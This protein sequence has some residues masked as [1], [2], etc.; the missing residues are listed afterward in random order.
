[1]KNTLSPYVMA[2][3]FRFN[4][5]LQRTGLQI[6]PRFLTGALQ[7][8]NVCDPAQP[9]NLYPCQLQAKWDSTYFFTFSL[10]FEVKDGFAIFIGMRRRQRIRNRLQS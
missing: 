3:S 8:W 7:I 6:L 2:F 1:L 9:Q 5:K 10:Q 4:S